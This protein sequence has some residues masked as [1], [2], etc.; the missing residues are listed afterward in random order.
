MMK[1]WLA[2]LILPSLAQ[3]QT[4]APLTTPPSHVRKHHEKEHQEWEQGIKDS[5]K[6][7]E[8]ECETNRLAGGGQ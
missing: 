3:A 7:R 2:L 5:H 8:Q 6:L 1:L 4:I